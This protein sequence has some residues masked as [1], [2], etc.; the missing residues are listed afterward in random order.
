MVISGYLLPCVGIAVSAALDRFV[1]K[2]R[3]VT[4]NSIHRASNDDQ[5]VRFVIDFDV[6]QKLRTATITYTLRD[7]EHPATV[8]AGK[9]RTL[10]FSNVGNNSEY[11][12]F[13]KKLINNG[14]W[15]LDVKVESSG[16]RINPLYKLFPIVSTVNRKEFHI[17]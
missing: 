2:R 9:T 15:L 4:I 1:L 14:D 11:L 7:K 3:M 16:S 8:I 12:L 10:E 5:Y 17:D 13:N 6:K